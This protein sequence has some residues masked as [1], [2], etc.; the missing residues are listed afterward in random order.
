MYL[1]LF[2][3]HLGLAIRNEKRAIGQ[4]KKGDQQPMLI[5][6]IAVQ[7]VKDWGSTRF[8]GVGDILCSEAG[9]LERH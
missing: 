8:C 5:S 7:Q 6:V 3:P 9:E 1:E 2:N 4:H